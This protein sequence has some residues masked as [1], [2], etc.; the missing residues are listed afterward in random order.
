MKNKKLSIAKF[1]YI[2]NYYNFENE[3]KKKAIHNYIIAI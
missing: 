2:K 1:S 3:K